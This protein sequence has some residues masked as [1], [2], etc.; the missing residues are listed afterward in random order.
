MTDVLNLGRNDSW[1]ACARSS[2]GLR[3]ERVAAAD[4]LPHL[5]AAVTVLAD[6]VQRRQPPQPEAELLEVTRRAAVLLGH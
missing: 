4:N 3:C 1:R 5:D 6:Q 2:R